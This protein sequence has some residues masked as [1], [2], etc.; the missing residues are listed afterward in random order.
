MSLKLSSRNYVWYKFSEELVLDGADTSRDL[1]LRKIQT[2]SP[3][4]LLLIYSLLNPF[5]PSVTPTCPY[6]QLLF[7]LPRKYTYELR[8]ILRINI[9][10]L[11]NW[12]K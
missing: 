1:S 9:Q 2:D 7:T 8:V 3:A 12:I 11:P 6:N 4:D 5:K 10:Y